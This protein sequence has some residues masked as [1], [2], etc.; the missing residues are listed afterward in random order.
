MEKI[1]MFF[2]TF[3][4]IEENES[5][6]LNYME[7]FGKPVMSK[8]CKNWRLYKQH[9]VL[10]GDNVPQYTGYFEIPDVEGFFK[11]EPSEEMKETIRQASEVCSNVREWLGERIV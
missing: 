8:Y 11:S 9:K 7:N 1:T 4:V 6:F 5:K 2:Y 3:D 10:S